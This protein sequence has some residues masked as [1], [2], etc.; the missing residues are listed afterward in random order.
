[1]L[2][3]DP[4]IDGARFW[5]SQGRATARDHRPARGRGGCRTG[6]AMPTRPAPGHRHRAPLDKASASLPAA[7]PSRLC[8]RGIPTRWKTADHAPPTKPLASPDH[9]RQLGKSVGPD[10]DGGVTERGLR[11]PKGALLARRSSRPGQALE[12]DTRA[13][14]HY[15]A[16]LER[17]DYREPPAPSTPGRASLRPRP[18]PG[19]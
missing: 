11:S 4:E 18:L 17:G 5:R 15:L 7:A 10:E 16:A 6:K 2:V 9:A 14:A 13:P 3:T 19:A 12:R 8:L 1:V